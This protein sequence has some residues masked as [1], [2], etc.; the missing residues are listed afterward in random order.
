MQKPSSITI[1][2]PTGYTP[3]D[4][5]ILTSRNGEILS[6][7]LVRVIYVDLDGAIEIWE[8]EQVC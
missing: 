8:A 3:G 5:Y 4:P 6:L 7:K 1:S 2:L